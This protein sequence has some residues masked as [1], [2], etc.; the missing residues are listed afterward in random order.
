MY[1]V[2]G[3]GP[4]ETSRVSYRTRTRKSMR[5]V[6][7]LPLPDYSGGVE[8]ST[9]TSEFYLSLNVSLRH[10]PS[11]ERE[12]RVSVNQADERRRRFR[13]RFTPGT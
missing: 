4:D 5:V 10:R 6:G 9:F 13:P 11:P 2:T 7:T 3:T 8:I 12:L 1:V